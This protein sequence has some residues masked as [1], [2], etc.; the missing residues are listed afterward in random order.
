VVARSNR[1]LEAERGSGALY[2]V[3]VQG[4][5]PRPL[6]IPDSGRHHLFPAFDPA[7]RSLA[8]ASCGDLGPSC[9]IS[10][11]TLTSDF[12][13]QGRPRQIKQVSAD[14]AG[15]AWAADGRS[16]VY[17]AGTSINDYFLWR[18]EVAGAEA[19]RLDIASA[20]A[21]FPAV[22]FKGPRLVFSRQMSD[23]DIW[24]VEVGGKSEPFLVSSM[25]DLNAEFS[26]DGRHIAFASARGVD[27]VAIWLSDANGANL[28]Q[29]TR[30]PGT[31]DGSPRWSP[32][33]R[34]IAFD[35]LGNDARRSV[36]V[37]ASM[38]G[39]SRHV[40]SSFPWSNKVPSWSRDGKW[41]YFTSDRTGRW[42]IWRIP[43]QG[44]T[45]EQITT[46]GGYVALES[47]DGKILYYTKMGIYGGEPLYA[48]A[49]GGSEERKVLERVA[50]RGF[51]VFE[52]GIYYLADTGARTIEIRFYEFATG[53]SRIVS[54]IEGPPG[55][56]LSVSPNRKTI[57]FTKFV[58]AGADLMLIENFR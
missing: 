23:Q 34:W 54:A 39:Q 35:A 25:L 28:A 42:E 19:S 49:L 10:L 55:L 47:A 21:V 7:G 12:L 56:G 44:G 51:V 22:A 31:Y 4:G 46:A 53:R 8:F 30:G 18:L 29:L 43:A 3:P 26:P 11:V 41:I 2:L 27:R 45:A 32:D 24:R 58:S 50:G 38:G 57:L 17:S 48:R 14:L 40:T 37:V 33:S 13:P 6:L 1:A 36:H 15:L 20:G 5:E 9:D 52:D 16:L